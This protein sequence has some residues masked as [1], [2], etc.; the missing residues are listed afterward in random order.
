MKTETKAFAE[1]IFSYIGYCLLNF[2]VLVLI[3]ALIG[4]ITN[5]IDILECLIASVIATGGA[6][7]AEKL[8]STDYKED[9]ITA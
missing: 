3:F 5:R 1:D 8:I 2:A 6:E 9:I 7:L 4:K